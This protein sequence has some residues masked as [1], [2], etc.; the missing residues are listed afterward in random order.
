M[1]KDAAKLASLREDFINGAVANGEDKQE[2]AQFWE[3]LLEFARY[4]SL[5]PLCRNIQMIIPLIAGIR[6]GNQQPRL[7]TGSTTSLKA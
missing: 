4:A 1:K 7:W 3:E 5:A 2:V 6:L